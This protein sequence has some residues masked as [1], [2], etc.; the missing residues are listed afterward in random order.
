MLSLRSIL[1]LLNDLFLCAKMLRELSMKDGVLS[2]AAYG[3][4]YSAYSLVTLNDCVKS[5]PV[6]R[7]T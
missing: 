6:R 4:L 3:W 5:A 1:S 2:W 7:T